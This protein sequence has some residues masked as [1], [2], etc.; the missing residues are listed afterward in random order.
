MPPFD[1]TVPVVK[2]DGGILSKIILLRSVVDFTTSPW[3]P[4]ESE[5]L[6]SNFTIPLLSVF[7]KK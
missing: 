2:S 3:L 7:L 4:E 5:K 6:I 1:V